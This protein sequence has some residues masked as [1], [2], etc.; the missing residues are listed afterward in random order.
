MNFFNTLIHIASFFAAGIAA[1][2]TYAYLVGKKFPL[3]RKSLFVSA[4]AGI[5]LTHL[6]DLVGEKGMLLKEHL[7]YGFF[8]S[9]IFA[10]LAA[11]LFAFFTVRKE[12][13]AKKPMKKY[14]PQI[15]VYRRPHLEGNPNICDKAG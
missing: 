8:S 5:I 1:F 15:S 12:M 10:V 3:T 2:K 9:I 13:A 7:F 14:V 11:C 6:A 4:V